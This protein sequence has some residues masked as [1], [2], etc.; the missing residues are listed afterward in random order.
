MEI[1]GK[2]IYKEKEE[3]LTCILTSLE[4]GRIPWRKRWK[5]GM[6]HAKNYHSGHV[7]QGINNLITGCSA[8]DTPYFLTQKQIEKLG[9]KLKKNAKA[10]PMVFWQNKGP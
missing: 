3:L 7:F 4:E 10:L 8:F 6:K 1:E 2:V 9:G 5:G